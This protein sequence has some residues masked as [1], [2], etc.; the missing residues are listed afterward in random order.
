MQ[1]LK[2]LAFLCNWAGRFESYLVGKPED[3][4][5]GDKAQM[6]AE[7]L[8]VSLKGQTGKNF[9]LTVKFPKYSDTQNICCNLSKI[10]TTWLYHRAISL[11]DADGKSNSVD[12]RSSLIWV[13][14][15]CSGISVRKLRIITVAG[16]EMDAE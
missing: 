16:A 3:R 6:Q 14:T 9:S 10:W 11:N 8:T 15:V 13:C 7:R 1:N 12:R 2:P 5:S 4:F